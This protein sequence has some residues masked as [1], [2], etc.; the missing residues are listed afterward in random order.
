MPLDASGLL[1]DLER[2]LRLSSEDIERFQ[3][4]EADDGS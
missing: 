3:R 4:K 2:L 1:E